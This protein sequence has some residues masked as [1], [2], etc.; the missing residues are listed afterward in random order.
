MYSPVSRYDDEL[1]DEQ[2]KNALDALM[3]AETRRI[4]LALDVARGATRYAFPRSDS[5]A[6]IT[7]A[8]G[9]VDKARRALDLLAAGRPAGCTSLLSVTSGALKIVLQDQVTRNEAARGLPDRLPALVAA[10]AVDAA[11]YQ[12]GFTSPAAA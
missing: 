3:L 4:A 7:R 10:D 11:T 6:A 5:D 2:T 9:D 12:S 1:I 8:L